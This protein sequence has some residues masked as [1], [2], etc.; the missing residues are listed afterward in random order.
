[1]NFDIMNNESMSRMF[2]NYQRV[3]TTL[4]PFFEDP[5]RCSIYND[6]PNTKMTGFT[7]IKGRKRLSKKKRKQ[8]KSND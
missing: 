5:E 1:M 6:R 8:L 7:Q 2:Y 4:D 3:V